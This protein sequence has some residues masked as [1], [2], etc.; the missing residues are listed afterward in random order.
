MIR[1]LHNQLKMGNLLN[2]S[3]R[4]N[5]QYREIIPNHTIPDVAPKAKSHP[6]RNYASN[7]IKT[8]KYTIIT[9]L[10]KNL[11]EQFHRFANLYFIF[12]VA[13][14][15][16]PQVQAFGKEIAMVPVIF[17]LAV[18]ACKDAFEDFR[19]YRS[20]K[21]VN[22]SKCRIYKEDKK[23]HQVDWQDVR[24]GDIMHLSC[25]DIIPADLL[26]L[27]SSDKSG[28]CHVET[29]NLD[30]E[31]NLK[32]RH[33]LS[34]IRYGRDGYRAEKFKYP[35]ECEQPNAEIYKFTGYM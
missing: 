34:G 14:N 5:P 3:N 7:R 24:V 15:W 1:I 30:G 16:V 31:T 29:M 19:R 10:P 17:V 2:R 25:N 4:S 6:N 20:D 22:L 9:F 33:C 23:F 18:T 26:L 8:T 32:Q 11:F 12:V 28:I 13:L 21:K 27:R 35:I